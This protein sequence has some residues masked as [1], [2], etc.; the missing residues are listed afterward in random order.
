[1]LLFIQAPGEMLQSAIDEGGTQPVIAVRSVGRRITKLLAQAADR[2]VGLLRQEQCSRV[3]WPGY[4]PAPEWPDA[5]ECAEQSAFPRT[6]RTGYEHAFSRLKFD[7]E[8]RYQRLP[9]RKIHLDVACLKS[10]L[11]L[12]FGN[13][14][15]VCVCFSTCAVGRRTEGDQPVNRRAPFCK[16]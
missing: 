6:G 1:M 14:S 4:H 9:V 13:D 5:R 7:A 12:S 3:A 11:V 8:R 15:G 2:E 16:L 10:G